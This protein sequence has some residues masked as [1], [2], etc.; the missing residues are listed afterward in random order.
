MYFFK[1]YFLI[2]CTFMTKSDMLLLRNVP[3]V[4]D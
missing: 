3:F 2:L 1:Q 4:I